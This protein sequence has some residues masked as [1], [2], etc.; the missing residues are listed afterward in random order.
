MIFSDLNNKD[1]LSTIEKNIRL[2]Q[3]LIVSH[4]IVTP[5]N[6]SEAELPDVLW[7]KLHHV[8]IIIAA[9]GSYFVKYDNM[10]ID[11]KINKTKT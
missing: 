10:H 5:L 3:D 2:N 8:N 4:T 7:K 9:D 1:I 6:F 11:E